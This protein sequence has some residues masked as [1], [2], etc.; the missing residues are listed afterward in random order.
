M[1]E[2]KPSGV[3]TMATDF[4]HKGPFAGVM[5]GV[6]LSRFPQA[7]IV[8]LAHDI[9]AAWPP[10]A[11]FWIARCWPYFPAGT[12]HI[13]IV[14]PGS[15]GGRNILAVPFDGHIFLAPDNGLLAPLIGSMTQ[16]LVYTV[17]QA[18]LAR[19]GIEDPNPMFQGRD[20]FAPM[21]AELAAGRIAIEALAKPTENWTPGWIDEPDVSEDRIAGAIVSVD[22][23]G[24]LLTNI[25]GT[26]LRDIEN[27]VAV[28]AGRHL[29]LAGDYGR[30][31][32]GE[33]ICLINSFGVLEIARIES[34][35]AE[36]LGVERGA[37][38]YVHSGSTLKV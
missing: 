21:A 22:A 37:P 30:A 36:G 25:D 35:A 14:D 34:S 24:N 5:R 13:A 33:F 18:W 31:P 8:D 23:F 11:G 15:A 9:P 12:V 19:I 29:A 1:N 7:S 20:I 16:P 10:E 26:L 3:I 27:P 32:P 28:V 2:F 6:I 17:E 38:V 4:G